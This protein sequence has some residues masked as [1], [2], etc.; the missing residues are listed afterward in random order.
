MAILYFF[1]NRYELPQPG[2]ALKN[3]IS[4]WQDCVNNS[5]AQLEHQ[6]V[7]LV[8]YRAIIIIIQCNNLHIATAI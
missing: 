7:R 6:N 1:A 5:Y 8:N 2:A 4:A 3:D